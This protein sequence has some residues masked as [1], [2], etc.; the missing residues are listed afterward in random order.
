M[1]SHLKKK[2]FPRLSL[3]F[4]IRDLIIFASHLSISGVKRS[5]KEKRP[6]WSEGRLN[7][8]ETPTPIP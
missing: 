8:C 3:T 4:L 7:C 5:L 6:N 1:A 2:L